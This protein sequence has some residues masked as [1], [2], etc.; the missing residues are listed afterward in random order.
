MLAS[1]PSRM[2][3]AIA[4]P[5]ETRLALRGCDEAAVAQFLFQH[6]DAGR[7][8]SLGAVVD[9]HRRR[10]VAEGAA[11]AGVV[12]V[13]AVE[14]GELGA[15]GGIVALHRDRR[16][17]YDAE[18]C[19]RLVGGQAARHLGFDPELIAADGG[20]GLGAKPSVYPPRIISHVVEYQLDQAL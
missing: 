11:V 7:R 19:G 4:A 6:R 1:R 13:A 14:R 3:A 8:I 18:Q 17:Q 12:E 2:A 5:R 10:R 9:R 15:V 16:A 20:P